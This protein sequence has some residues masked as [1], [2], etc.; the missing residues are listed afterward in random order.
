M[1]LLKESFRGIK[2]I[3]ARK[4]TEQLKPR[5]IWF[6]VTDRC[7][8]RCTHC[9]IWRKKSTSNPLTL[10]EIERAFRSPLFFGLECILNSGGE[11]V[12]RE[13]IE[14]LLLLERAIFPNAKLH[15]STNGLLAERVVEV[16]RA[17]SRKNVSLEVGVSLDGV[18]EK[19]DRIRGVSGN[20]EKIDR[21]LRQL[22]ALRKE[23]GTV[24]PLV[25]FT[26]SDLTAENFAEVKSY[27][28]SVGVPFAVQWYNQSSFYDNEG[29]NERG[30]PDQEKISC[31]VRSLPSNFLNEK[32]LDSLK[33][34][35]I[36]FPCF[37]AFTFCVLKCN[38]DIVPC[39]SFWDKKIGNIRD[40]DPQIIWHSLQAKEVRSAVKG[41]AG[42]LNSWGLGWSVNS[43]V[44]HAI[45]YYLKR[46]GLLLKRLKKT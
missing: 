3:Y 42:C 1:N 36:A 46:P 25:G 18:G 38:G 19:H 20:F 22:V 28:D 27:A 37:A 32:W 29:K 13:D 31:V 34:K 16:V 23:F 15:L 10:K 2:N 7:N 45:M 43:Y 33:G 26:L 35:S 24:D 40:Q 8:S 4:F 30:S 21:L 5:W 11:P 44:N 39:L 17:L 6:E 12:L 14:D 41:C 9:N